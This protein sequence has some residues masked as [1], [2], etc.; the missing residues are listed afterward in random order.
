M[1]VLLRKECLSLLPLVFAL[2]PLYLFNLAE[3]FIISSP[4]QV[5][6]ERHSVL[7]DIDSSRAN[8][9][10]YILIGLIAAYLVLPHEKD[11]NTVQFLWSMPVRRRT[12]FIAKLFGIAAVLFALTLL[13]YLLVLW[14]QSFSVGSISASQFSFS[15]WLLELTL[16]TG[17]AWIGAAYG[18]LIAC[19]RI[20]GILCFAVFWIAAAGMSLTQP[21]LLYL[22]PGSLLKTEF[23]GTDLLLHSKA[24]QFHLP[25]ATLCALLAGY[26]WTR[27]NKDAALRDKRSKQR[28]NFILVLT[29]VV[30]ILSAI[31]YSTAV[32][33]P[34]SDGDSND[35]QSL[36]T[37]S[38]RHF[39]FSF[40]AEDNDNARALLMEA[41]AHALK[42]AEQLGQDVPQTISATL[43]DENV[44]HLG[45]AGWRKL[46]MSRDSLQDL[47]ERQHV[48]VHETA[49]VIAAEAS[50]RRLREHFSHSQF[51]I[52]GLAEWVSYETLEL[53]EQR[54]A[55]RLL[56]ALAWHRFDMR[57]DDL[58]FSASFKRRFDQNLIYALGE[59]WVSA[60]ANTCGDQSVG[61]VLRSIGRDDAPELS[62]AAFWRDSLQHSGCDFYAVNANF[63]ALLESYEPRI[64]DAPRWDSAVDVTNQGIRV[65][66]SI[67]SG[68]PDESYRVF[69][70]ARDSADVAG[71]ATVQR[72]ATIKRGE[73]AD[74]V[75]NDIPISGSR[76]QY[77]V[78]V[79]FIV[80]ER[81]IYGLWTDAG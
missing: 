33:S 62:G 37:A 71:P 79:E 69:V 78:G 63:A 38:S 7:L 43:T 61:N 80:G 19:F 3:Y 24:W 34:E 4:D 1:R 40:Y 25:V 27:D 29:A 31:G 66:V 42:V 30:A 64:A 57:M 5:D 55:L 22:D 44:D 17:T 45:I 56:A 46:R 51:F 77:Q 76:F 23:R 49:H 11:R 26:F 73:S 75:F 58:L 21:S 12:T 15:R 16:V 18:S 2:L 41:D 8:G 47:A 59:A 81:P 72:S 53:D 9:V 20:P 39:E 67:D 65:S 13:D 35:E 10:I 60:L 52:E 54:D 36:V 50:D 70:R 74:L 28:S 32:L 48:F 68:S 14:I 6:Y